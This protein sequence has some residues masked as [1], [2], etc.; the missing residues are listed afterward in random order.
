[1][2]KILIPTDFTDNAWNATKYAAH[3]SSISHAD[4][5]LLHAW[6]V[7]IVDGAPYPEDA[8]EDLE[9]YN[10]KALADITD[11]IKKIAP[12]SV[13]I[14]TCNM[15]GFAADEILECAGSENADLI[16]LGAQTHGNI[17]EKTLGMI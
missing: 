7:P 17:I 13:K 9:E 5:L 14:E 8:V 11:K 10:R 2:K 15:P 12:E 3:L 1:M 6:H 16:V 4:I